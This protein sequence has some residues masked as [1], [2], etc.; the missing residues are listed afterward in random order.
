MK[1]LWAVV[2]SSFLCVSVFCQDVKPPLLAPIKK[3]DLKKDSYELSDN[4]FLGHK[5]GTL[6]EFQTAVFL[7]EKMR[8]L[9][10]SLAGDDTISVRYF[11][12][13]Y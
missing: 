7:A 1:S 13:I 6:K 9:G 12:F 11:V 10:M 8:K 2:V 3:A 4:H 5:E